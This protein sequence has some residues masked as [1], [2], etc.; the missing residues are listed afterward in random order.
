MERLGKFSLR[1]SKPLSQHLDAGYPAHPRQLLGGER[2]RI[3][4]R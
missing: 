2:L 1:H 3:G 4:V